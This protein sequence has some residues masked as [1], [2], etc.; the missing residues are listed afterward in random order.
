[1]NVETLEVRM[2]VQGDR[3]EIDTGQRAQSSFVV[4]S[5]LPN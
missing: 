4:T 5:R 2:N 1:M 3:V